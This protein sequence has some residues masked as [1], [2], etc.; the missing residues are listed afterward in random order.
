MFASLR[1]PRL[2]RQTTQLA[3]F[4]FVPLVILLAASTFLEKKYGTAW[5]HKHLYQAI[6]FTALWAITGLSAAV[7][8][9]QQRKRLSGPVLLLHTAFLLILAGAYITR[10]TGIQG[11][12]HLRQDIE[13]TAYYT[14]PDARITQLP[15]SL[16][17]QRFSTSYYPGT[18]HPS[19]YISVVQVTH[20]DGR[21]SMQRISMNRIGQAGHWRLYQS[22]FDEDGR[23]SVLTVNCDPWG[24][25]ITYTGYALLLLAFLTVLFHRKGLFRNSLRQLS[26]LTGLWLLGL[27]ATGTAEAR[28]GVDNGVIPRE[29]ADLFRPIQLLSEGRIQP[30]GTFALHFT[31]KITGKRR[32]RGFTN[33]QIALGWMLFPDVWKYEPMIEVNSRTLCRRLGIEKRAALQDFFTPE[34]TYRL[35]T[36]LT[37]NETDLLQPARE[38][39]EKVELILMLRQGMLLRAFPAG[40]P[41][42]P[43]WYAPADSLPPSVGSEQRN[44]IREWLPL[45]RSELLAKHTDSIRLYADKLRSYQNR[46]GGNSLL[47]ARRIQTELTYNRL[48]LSVWVSRAALLLGMVGLVVLTI[49]GRRRA[50]SSA[51]DPFLA[52][53]NR[54]LPTKVVCLAPFL[55]LG[56]LLT[57]IGLRTAVCGRLPLGN[58]YETLLTLAALLLTLAAGLGRRIALAAPLGTLLA[59]F[60]LLVSGFSRMDSQIMPLAPVLHSP[61]LGIHVSTIMAAYAL[62]SLLLLNSLTALVHKGWRHRP[63]SVLLAHV[64]LVPALAL[65]ATG[66]FLGAV[67][68][69]VSWGN[70]WSWDPKETWALIT[71]LIYALPVHRRTFPALGHPLWLHL[72]LCC[73][74]A[75]VLMTYLGVNY[76]LGG[77]HSYA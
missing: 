63:A 7:A 76:F 40:D 53:R 2:L 74:F 37:G 10:L 65:L 41:E 38:T 31:R 51:S 30:F 18:D 47:S 59:G 61:L 72:Y 60:C 57:E 58:G 43:V 29:Q 11:V 22:S 26:R 39:H 16:R 15:F 21:R 68:A 12:V 54:G 32:Y 34:G 4:W 44:L 14:K 25:G 20:P 13:V 46:H 33:E 62:L 75:G 35:G 3:F 66:I 45:L 73:A 70:Y 27:F 56:V 23:G 5:A 42:S 55:L 77:L 36:L 64:L 71:L 24:T 17:L 28:T 9:W 48:T 69:N 52:R 8:L 19:D 1:S 49:P 67:W 6:W 50:V